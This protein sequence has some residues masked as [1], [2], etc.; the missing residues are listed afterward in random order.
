MKQTLLLDGAA[1]TAI[2]RLLTWCDSFGFAIAWASDNALLRAVVNHGKKLR[3][4]AVGTHF[5][6]TQPAALQRLQAL[7]N[8]KVVLPNNPLFHPKVWWFMRGNAIRCVVGSHNLTIAAHEGRNTEASALFEHGGTS[9]FSDSLRAFVEK[10]WDTAHEIDDDFLSSYALQ[11]EAARRHRAALNRFVDL[12]KAKR[13][14]LGRTL[15]AL[16]WRDFVA[17]VLADQHHSAKG[18]LAIL[19]TARGLFEAKGSLAQMTRDERRAVAGTYGKREPQLGGH[20]WAW[21]G[22]M[23]GQGDFKNLINEDFGGISAALDHIPLVGDVAQENYTA[24]TEGFERAFAT[25]AHKGGVATASRLLAMKR[26]DW[27]LG[28]NSANRTKTCEAFGSAP[29]TLS[30]DNYWERVIEP[31][32]LSAW[33]GVDRPSG[34]QQGRIWDNRA[35][36]LDSLYYDP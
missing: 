34:V 35:A 6:Q 26:P 15:L 28:V 7:D 32:H 30:L 4:G 18:R 12:R 36:L 10:A 19:G 13:S 17:G 2:R 20:D 5:Y 21:F 24:F 22:T 27:F 11:A 33:W 25:K 14:R 29:S 23:F 3:H 1:S 31:L 9:T 8:A 16:D